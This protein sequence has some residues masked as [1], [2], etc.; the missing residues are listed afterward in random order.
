M[1]YCFIQLLRIS[2]SW[3]LH[4]LDIFF[5]FQCFHVFWHNKMLHGHVVLYF[6]S[7]AMKSGI[8]PRSPEWYLEANIGALRV[9]IAIGESL[10][11]GPLSNRT[12]QHTYVYTQYSDNYIYIYFHIHHIYIENHGFIPVVLIEH[13][14]FNL[15]LLFSFISPLLW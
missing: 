3:L 9:L 12:R 14:E 1:L 6:H 5:F 7:S 13:R 4:P 8:F 2:S 15:V 10:F 11:P